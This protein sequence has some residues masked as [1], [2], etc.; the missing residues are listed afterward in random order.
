MFKSIINFFERI[1]PKN[2]H[3][4]IMEAEVNMINNKIRE[5]EDEIQ[6]ASFH[7]KELKD[8]FLELKNDINGFSEKTSNSDVNQEKN[9]DEEQCKGFPSF[10]RGILKISMNLSFE[11][12]DCIKS[13]LTNLNEKTILYSGD[14]T[15]T[16]LKNIAPK[17]EGYDLFNIE[18][19]DNVHEGSMEKK[20]DFYLIK[21]LDESVIYGANAELKRYKNY[22]GGVTAKDI[23]KNMQNFS[24]AFKNDKS[25]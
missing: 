15:E 20:V 14:I 9:D 10:E 25:R 1:R 12:I 5:L 18:F 2:N 22:F 11:F 7:S 3:E 6:L 17:V 24:E 19:L 21:I 4:L 8:S 16:I 13:G 23:E